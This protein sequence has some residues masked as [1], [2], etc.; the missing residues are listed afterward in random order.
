MALL[1]AKDSISNI[2]SLCKGGGVG[3][4]DPAAAEPMF[5]ADL[6]IN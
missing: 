6:K 5:T 1:L 2:A 3:P 4:A